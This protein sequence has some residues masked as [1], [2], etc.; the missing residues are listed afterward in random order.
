ML[1]VKDLSLIDREI[2]DLTCLLIN[3]G[4]HAA[5]IEI[6]YAVAVVA[7]SAA[8]ARNMDLSV[9]LD[10]N[11][12]YCIDRIRIDCA[13]SRMLDDH[14]LKEMRAFLINESLINCFSR[15]SLAV[16]LLDSLA[17]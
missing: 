16:D 3:G 2:S 4:S 8:G 13:Y 9:S 11:K 17:A 6:I 5:A 12:S 1:L 10:C 7:E 14:L 15:F